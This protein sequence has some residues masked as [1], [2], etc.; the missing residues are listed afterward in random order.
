MEAAMTYLEPCKSIKELAEA[1]ISLAAFGPGY[2]GQK[3]RGKES[4][5]KEK[6]Q[7]CL[8][9]LYSQKTYARSEKLPSSTT[10]A[11]TKS[12]LTLSIMVHSDRMPSTLKLCW[13]KK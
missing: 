9:A 5:R 3:G 10:L 11:D 7:A 4:E 1:F 2:A 6:G 8:S 12:T 13:K